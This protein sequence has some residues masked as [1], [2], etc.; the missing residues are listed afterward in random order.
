MNLFIDPIFEGEYRAS[1]LVLVDVGSSG[2]PDPRWRPAARHLRLIGFDADDRSVAPAGFGDTAVTYLNMALH[3]EKTHVD[4]HLLRKQ[5]ASS[6][7]RVSRRFVDAFPESERFD[8]IR[9]I[10]VDTDTLDAQLTAA[11]IGDV[12][13]IKVDTQGSELFVLE[14]AA[15]ALGGCFGLEVEVEFAP[16]YEGQPLFG[17]ID[18]LLRQR[19]FSLFDLRPYHWKR[20]AGRHFGG[21]KGQL[22]SADALYFRDLD[23]FG[24][25]LDRRDSAAS[26]RANVLHA[27]TVCGAYGYLDYA[28]EIGVTFQRLFS[29]GEQ[30]ALQRWA[31][32]ST[33]LVSRLP[34]FPGRGRLASLLGQ[35]HRA[36]MPTHRGWA[37]VGP[38][39]G[40]QP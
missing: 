24:A 35:M 36:V 2:G 15:G 12:D 19:G 29:V 13:F 14:G 3:R 34:Y 10:Q 26:V 8:V 21:P 17:D 32:R 23:A 18:G 22:V 16:I 6:I 38:P 11:G 9:S 25:A 1:P 28:V 5:E 37:T 20:S 7:Y 31:R 33:R 30:K 40:N 39:L 27:M 4:F